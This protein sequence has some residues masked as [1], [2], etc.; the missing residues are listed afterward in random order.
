MELKPKATDY[1]EI[2]PGLEIVIED[3]ADHVPESVI[4]EIPVTT[5]SVI[6]ETT[7]TVKGIMNEVLLE[8][9]A[10][11]VRQGAARGSVKEIAKETIVKYVPP[12][13]WTTVMPPIQRMKSVAA[14][15]TETKN[16]TEIVP[17]LVCAIVEA[18]I[19][20]WSVKCVHGTIANPVA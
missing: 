2:A 8:G 10:V 19:L 11:I 13:M 6:H 20:A 18:A 5:G 16:A 1:A 17:M 14:A 3:A 15:T 7:E 9:I 12:A 4:L